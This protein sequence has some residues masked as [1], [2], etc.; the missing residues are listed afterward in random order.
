ME[1]ENITKKYRSIPVELYSLHLFL[2]LAMICFVNKKTVNKQF[3]VAGGVPP[4]SV[5]RYSLS[6]VMFVL[7]F[8]CKI[9]S[10]PIFVEV[11]CKEEY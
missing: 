10:K 11:I 9:K 7:W 8:F 5:S 3:V 4:L 6:R 1:E 2:F